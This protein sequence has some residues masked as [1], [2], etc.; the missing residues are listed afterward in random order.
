MK[1][2][3]LSMVDGR[4]RSRLVRLV[5]VSRRRAVGLGPRE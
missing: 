4:G 1:V 3:E 2:V 5:E